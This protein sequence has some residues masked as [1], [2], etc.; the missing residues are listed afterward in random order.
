MNIATREEVNTNPAFDDQILRAVKSG[1][2]KRCQ[3][4]SLCRGTSRYT[5][6]C[7]DGT[8]LIFLLVFHSCDESDVA[9]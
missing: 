7:L 2:A 4:G 1:R 6:S 8:D 3:R 5:Y 9:K